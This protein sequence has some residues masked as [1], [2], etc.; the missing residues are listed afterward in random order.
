M[1]VVIVHNIEVA[2]PALET[3]TIEILA[4]GRKTKCVIRN[5]YQ[6]I[7]V[8]L[9]DRKKQARFSMLLLRFINS[10]WHSLDETFTEMV[11]GY[12]HLHCL[13]LHIGVT[14]IVLSFTIR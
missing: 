11:E 8:M 3:R 12:G 1:C 14:C 7:V 4:R 5:I 9:L 10:P 6:C 13:V 2:M